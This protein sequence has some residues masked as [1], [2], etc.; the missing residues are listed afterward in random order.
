MSRFTV[1]TNTETDCTFLRG[2]YW[3]VT[4]T[5]DLETNATTLI[6]SIL[7]LNQFWT[8][9]NDPTCSL[10]SSYFLISGGH[11]DDVTLEAGT[12][13]FEK[14]H[15]HRF[16]GDNMLHIERATTI[17]KAISYIA[18]E[19]VMRPLLGFYRDDIGMGHQQEWGR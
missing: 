19:W 13:A 6:E 14:Q 9:L 10:V 4:P 18:R 7:G 5:I 3:I 17:N 16:H 1:C 8:M 12:A 11:K 15:G 2:L